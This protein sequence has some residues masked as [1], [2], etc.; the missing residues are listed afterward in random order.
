M[1]NK[2]KRSSG[3]SS[4]FRERDIFKIKAVWIIVIL[5][6]VGFVFGSMGVPEEGKDLK[7]AVAMFSHETCTFCPRPTTIKDWEYYGPPTRDILGLD[8]G[9]IGGFKNM[10]EE[11]GGIKLVGILSPRGARGGS[12]GSWITKEAFDKYTTLIAGDLKQAGPFDGV[13]L[14]LHGAMAVTGVPKPEAEIV[15]RVRKVVGDIPIMVSLDLHANEDHELS[16]AADAVFIIKRY[17]HYDTNLIGEYAGRVMIKTIRGKYKPTMATRKPGVITPSVFQG[18]GVSPAMDI[19]ERARRWECQYSDVYVSVAFGFAYADV[20]D[21][22][23]T[24]MVVTNNNQGLADM[25]ADD[26]S[27]YIWRV[28]KEFAGKKLPK[29]KKGVALAI[30]AAR[31]GKTPVVIADHSDR[32][33][34][35]TYILEELIRQGAENFCI[36]TLRD[37]KALEE[38]KAKVKVGDT[39]SIDLGGY[40]DKFAG[41]PVRIN[42]KVEFLGNYGRGTVAVLVFGKN[43]R[44]ILT[45]Q[46]MQVTTPRIF[47][48][49]GIKL[50]SLDIIVL[51]SRVHFRRGFH[52]TGLAGAIFEVDAPGWGPADLTLL[53]YKN[54]PKDIYPIYKKN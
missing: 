43:N 51:K 31:A 14:S 33:G 28:R 36:A 42:G 23:A 17:P 12:S 35:S 7:I 6:L 54:I 50:E 1:S 41:N 11:Y 13:F 32:T 44:V 34:G 18:T 4:F 30:G 37:E 27:G 20:P 49:L 8:R 39:I 52:E 47:R 19:M 5:L 15:R 3:K 40:S 46:L 26:M 48:P 2:T 9:Y 16:D 29:T 22:G 38:I 21:V 45:P 25:I 24:V 53:P 10:C